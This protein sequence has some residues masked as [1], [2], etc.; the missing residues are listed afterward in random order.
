MI[1]WSRMWCGIGM[2]AFSIDDGGTVHVS[3]GGPTASCVLL[4]L[5][6]YVILI[7][8]WLLTLMTWWLCCF[9]SQINPYHYQCL[10][11][12]L[13][14]QIFASHGTFNIWTKCAKSNNKNKNKKERYIDFKYIN[15]NPLWNFSSFLI[16][17]C[18]SKLIIS[19]KI[20]T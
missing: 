5:F 2:L 10:K 3:C 19:I 11:W 13:R 17:I 6:N 4:W 16:L 18:T 12:K 1:H 15:F 9:Y 20:K 14:K 7:K 8:V